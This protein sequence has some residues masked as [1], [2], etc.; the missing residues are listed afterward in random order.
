MTWVWQLREA[1]KSQQW[2]DLISIKQVTDT[3]TGQESVQATWT[4]AMRS[5]TQYLI[6]QSAHGNL[7]VPGVDILVQQARITI[8]Q[9]YRPLSIRAA[10]QKQFEI[11]VAIGALVTLSDPVTLAL[12]A[13]MRSAYWHALFECQ[14]EAYKDAAI[15]VQKGVAALNIATHALSH[16]PHVLGQ[17]KVRA[18]SQSTSWLYLVVLCH[19]VFR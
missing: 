18:G 11:G 2:T 3:V 16:D 17:H 4:G 13:G 19:A 10:K 8:T 7:S 12:T 15:D 14:Y 1:V 6:Q 9:L 5:I